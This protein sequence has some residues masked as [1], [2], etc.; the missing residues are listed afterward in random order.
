VWLKCKRLLQQ[1]LIVFLVCVSFF[2]QAKKLYKYQ[3]EQGIWHYTDRQPQ[4]DQE[5]EIRQLK[6]EPQQRVWLKQGGSKQHPEYFALNHYPGP[7]E[8][9]VTVLEAQNV[10][11]SPVLPKRFELQPGQSET[12]FSM[13]G[14]NPAQPWRYSLQYAYVIGPVIHESPNRLSYR[15]PFAPGQRFQ[16]TQ[17]FN[18]TFS[19]TDPQNRY[20]VDF[21]MPVETPIHAA[22]S[23]TVLEVNNDY[24]VSGTQQAY[25]SRAN[26]IRILHDDGSMA[27]YA[28][29][30][31]EK[32]QVYPGLQVKAGQLIGYSGNTGFSTGPHL[33]FAVQINQGMELVSVPFSFQGMTEPK[34]GQWLHN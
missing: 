32:A 4:T 22:R 26:S 8:L 24:F 25:K 14:L 21:A 15:P 9:E 13:Q 34:A 19:H 5:V 28:H 7:V 12:L 23:G 1:F 30:A 31:L 17:G 11:S 20:A 16:I 3:D 27:V 33:H 10:A 29:L 18:G 2:A 6:V